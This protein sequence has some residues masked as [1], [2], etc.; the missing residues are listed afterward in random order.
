MMRKQCDDN[1]TRAHVAGETLIEVLATIIIIATAI[2]A[3]IGGLA[4]TILAT[5]HNRDLATANTL[6]RSYAEGVKQYSR[7]GYQD[8]AASYNVPATAYV[9]PNGWNV[10]TNTVMS[11]CPGGTDPGTQQVHI[12]VTTPGNVSQTLD[13]WVRRV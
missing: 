6:M 10:P 8:C 9:L 13:V 11:P 1:L 7:A 4:T 2:S 5:S 3:L 12:I